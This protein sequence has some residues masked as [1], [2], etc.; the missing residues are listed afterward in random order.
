MFIILFVVMVSWVSTC[1]SSKTVQ[2]KNMWFVF[3][4]IL[5]KLSKQ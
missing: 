1:Q 4:A 3:N 2:F 5:I